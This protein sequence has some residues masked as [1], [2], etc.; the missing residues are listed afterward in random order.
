MNDLQVNERKIK[1]QETTLLGD[2][3]NVALEVNQHT[4]GSMSDKF[5][6]IP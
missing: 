5:V 1:I 6:Y 4:F 2:Q 3:E